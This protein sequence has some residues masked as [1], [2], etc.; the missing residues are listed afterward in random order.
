MRPPV[1]DGFYQGVFFVFHP[2]KF[3][4]KQLGYFYHRKK[5]K[6]TDNSQLVRS[7]LGGG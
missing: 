6:I 1:K 5:E 4:G 7:F 2:L 3:G